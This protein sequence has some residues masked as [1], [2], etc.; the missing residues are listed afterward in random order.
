MSRYW[1][2]RLEFE[3][4]ARNKVERM[5]PGFGSVS[6]GGPEMNLGVL[7]SGR[8]SNL[9]AIL[10]AVAQ[11]DLQA[12][13]SLVVS[14]RP[15]AAG[16]KRAAEAGVP[17]CT[18]PH[19]KFSSR[20]LFEQALVAALREAEV[21]TIALAGF[22]RIVTATLLDAFPERVV[23]IH[24]ALLP[25]FPGLHA[26]RQALD[27][28]ARISGVTVHFV[29][30]KMDHGP[31]IAQAVVAVADD[32]TEESLAA[33]ILREEHR[34]YPAALQALAAGELHRNGRRVLGGPR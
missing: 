32:D 15:N 20:I 4:L 30:E 24:P 9:A 18:L 19:V 13:I 33:R 27:H 1:P 7:I 25:A 10:D 14:N 34:L 31:I 22:D 6:R 17:V 11:G 28:G 16:L 12:T 5:D 26:Q 23:N 2:A 8:G 29:D 3:E 21:D